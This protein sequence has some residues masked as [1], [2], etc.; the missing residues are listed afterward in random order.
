MAVKFNVETNLKEHI[1]IAKEAVVVE[2]KLISAINKEDRALV[3]KLKTERKQITEKKKLNALDKKV[4]AGEK[5]LT[6]ATNAAEKATERDARAKNKSAAASQRLADKEARLMSSVKKRQ[7][8]LRRQQRDSSLGGRA[9]RGVSGAA[10][11]AVAA[12]SVIAVGAAVAGA[13]AGIREASAEALGFADTMT[14]L[15]S[16]GD[17][18]KNFDSVKRSVESLSISSG[19][20][21]QEIANAMFTMQ[22]ATANLSQSIRDDL[23]AESIELSKANGTQLEPTLNALTTTYQIYGKEVK[24]VADLQNKLQLTQQRGKLTFEDLA[25]FLP[26]V[27]SA[28]QAMGFSLNEVNAALA[29]ATVKGGRSDKTFT[30]LRNVF[31]RIEDAEKKGI[32]LTGTFAE[33]LGQLSK[34]D[35]NTLKELFGAESIA[36]INNLVA[37]AADFNKELEI[38]KNIRGDI[39]AQ[40]LAGRAANDPFFKVSEDAKRKEQVTAALKRDPEMAKI[41]TDF[42]AQ[43]EVFKATLAGIATGNFGKGFGAAGRFAELSEEGRLTEVGNKALSTPGTMDDIS[44]IQ[45]IQGAEGGVSKNLEP[46]LLKLLDSIN[47]N[48]HVLNKTRGDNAVK[49]KEAKGL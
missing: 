9:R 1:A 39:A 37:G 30:G 31:L 19:K 43:F 2:R 23:L 7:Q 21:V 22:S 34:V 18:A 4:L 3:K 29:V 16:L 49:G 48:S 11:L 47:G 13:A 36:V 46:V 33:K 14:A 15:L 38:T 44:A 45:Q 28:A 10:G 8:A 40:T 6:R 35:K 42:Q 27:A 17:N 25:T 20:S 5:A 41:A 32:K 24:N 26:G 12:G